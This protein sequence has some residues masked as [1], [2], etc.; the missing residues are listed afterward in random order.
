M[1]AKDQIR[2]SLG[3]FCYFC[4]HI[5]KAAKNDGPKGRAGS[6]SYQVCTAAVSP[7]ALTAVI[8]IEEVQSRFRS[9]LTRDPEIHLFRDYASASEAH[10]L[11][12]NLEAS[13]LC[14]TKRNKTL[15]SNSPRPTMK[16]LASPGTVRRIYSR[17]SLSTMIGLH[18]NHPCI[19]IRSPAPSPLSLNRVSRGSPKQRLWHRLLPLLVPNKKKKALIKLPKFN[20][21]RKLRGIGFKIDNKS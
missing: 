9:N 21:R 4:R 14:W 3:C 8:N 19:L 12:D 1:T 2:Q 7:N 13:R 11:N 15:L 5:I 10:D 17:R 6:C 16:Q 18:E 20:Q